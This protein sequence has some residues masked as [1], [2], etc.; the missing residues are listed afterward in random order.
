MFFI[1]SFF[2]VI[3]QNINCQNPMDMWDLYDFKVNSIET[4]RLIAET[5]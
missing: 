1:G 3:F 2:C 4:D 5:D